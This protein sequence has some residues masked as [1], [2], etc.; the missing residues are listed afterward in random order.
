MPASSLCRL[1]RSGLGVQNLLLSS[2]SC[3]C[4]WR[5]VFRTHHS[6]SLQLHLGAKVCLW[7]F[8]W[9]LNLHKDFMRRSSPWVDLW[10]HLK[11]VWQLCLQMCW[12]FRGGYL[13][14]EIYKLLRS[15]CCWHDDV[16]A[17]KEPSHRDDWWG[18]HKVKLLALFFFAILASC[19]QYGVLHVRIFPEY[20]SCDFLGR[21]MRKW[22]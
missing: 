12:I 8:C 14:E 21:T 6:S 4:V 7:W 17:D 22:Y 15:V 18:H 16:T 19:I 13:L 2:K 20:W 9:H 5:S 3:R 11:T 10:H 1:S